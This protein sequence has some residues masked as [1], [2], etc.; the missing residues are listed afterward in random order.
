M[1]TRFLGRQRPEA[2]ISVE[3]ALSLFT[4]ADGTVRQ[5]RRPVAYAQTRNGEEIPVGLRI[6]PLLFGWGLL[7][8]V[9]HEMLK[10]FHDP[11]DKNRDGISGRLRN[12]DQGAGGVAPA[13]GWKASH[14]DLDEQIA[15]ALSNDIGVNH[16]P[17]AI[18][19]TD[20][21]LQ[22]IGNFVRSLGVPNR[23]SGATDR[24]RDLFGLTGCTSCHITALLTRQDMPI[25]YSDQL[26]WPYSDF[27]LHDMGP[28]LADPGDAEDASEW[29]TAPL[30]GIGYAEAFLPERGFLHDG[31]AANIEEAI[32]WHG[33]EA[34]TSVRAFSQL[35]ASDR[36]LLLSYVRAL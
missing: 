4:Y 21:E 29:R 8:A 15:S 30:W 25:E 26:I 3:T 2:R 13:L 32:L 18:E 33:G 19:V 11:D 28:G 6:A 9:D 31:R 14:E 35:S 27:M 17:D 5:L 1:T 22:A 24:G 23:R 34:E 10:H 12:R 36:A 20:A 7:D 16:T